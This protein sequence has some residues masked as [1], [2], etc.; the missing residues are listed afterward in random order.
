MSDRLPG[1]EF[2]VLLK[3]ALDVV[4]LTDIDDVAAFGP[5]CCQHVRA[6]GRIATLEPPAGVRPEE[7]HRLVRLA[8]DDVD[9]TPGRNLRKAPDVSAA[10]RFDPYAILNALEHQRVTYVLIGGFARVIQGTEELTR[11][12]D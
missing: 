3:A 9:A 4:T 5:L 8:H 2:R 7:R 10:D 6:C 11:G 12:L 1:T